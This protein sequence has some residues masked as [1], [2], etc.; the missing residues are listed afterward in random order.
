MTL[1]RS[2][3]LVLDIKLLKKVLLLSNDQNELAAVSFTET[4]EPECDIDR[5]GRSVV[6]RV[7]HCLQSNVSTR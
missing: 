5:R 7:Q 6:E 2:V 3:H 4:H 1:L